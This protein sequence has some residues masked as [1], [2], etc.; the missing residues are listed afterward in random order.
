MI[1]TDKRRQ[2]RFD[3]IVSKAL[4]RKGVRYE[5]CLSDHVRD[6]VL[7]LGVGPHSASNIASYVTS[8]EV[9]MNLTPRMVAQ[10]AICRADTVAELQAA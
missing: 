8:R 2:R 9:R 10:C 3:S 7:I 1:F 5:G 4:R 6:V